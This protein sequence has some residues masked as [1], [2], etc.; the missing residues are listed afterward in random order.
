MNSSS[1]RINT[2]FVTDMLFLI[3]L[4][5]YSILINT[6]KSNVIYHRK[7]IPYSIF[8]PSLFIDVYYLVRFVVYCPLQRQQINGLFN[9]F[10]HLCPV[11]GASVEIIDRSI[12]Q[13][14]SI[15]LRNFLTIRLSCMFKH[16]YCDAT[17]RIVFKRKNFE[18]RGP[19]CTIHC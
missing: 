10:Y 4:Y 19:I 6:L 12:N 3:T 11:L 16:I 17:H 14:L 9:K 13:R 7:V 8:I 2:E 5:V 1:Y 18:W 15:R